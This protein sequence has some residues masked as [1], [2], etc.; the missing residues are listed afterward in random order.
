MEHAPVDPPPFV[1]ENIRSA[2]L[3]MAQAITTQAQA[4]MS[5]AQGMTAKQIGRFAPSLLTSHYYG[6][7]F[8]VLHSN[9]P[10]YLLQVYG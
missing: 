1:D 2:L 6:F 4:A 8:K 9:E 5:Q 3:Q 7:T 10:S